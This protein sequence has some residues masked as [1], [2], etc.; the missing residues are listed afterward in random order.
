VSRAVTILRVS[1][2]IAA[3]L[4]SS[5]DAV[6]LCAKRSGKVVVREACKSRETAVLPGGV[7]IVGPPGAQGP[8]GAAGATAQVP[9]EV[10]DS[11]GKQFGTLLRWDG[12]LAQVVA[13]V[14]GV[15]VPFQFTI[16]DGTFFNESLQSQILHDEIGCAGNA[17]IRDVGG[18][19][20]AVH[21]FGPRAYFSRTVSSMTPIKSREF[22]PTTPGDCGSSTPTG[23]ETCCFDDTSTVNVSP[24]ESFETSVLGVKP[25]FSVV[26]Q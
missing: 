7:A 8:A 22:T 12:F 25:P 5:A 19:V 17:F 1:I 6:V 24:A 10:V 3:S 11:T 20:P 26:T 15:D 18:L 14:P 2:L 21:V 9:Q 23:R 13:A 4:Q 16:V